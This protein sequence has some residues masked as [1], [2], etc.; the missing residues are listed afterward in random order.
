MIFANCFSKSA[1]RNHKYLGM[2]GGD[3]SDVDEQLLM[4]STPL[5]EFFLVSCGFMSL[6][7]LSPLEDERLFGSEFSMSC[8]NCDMEP[9]GA[10]LLPTLC[11]SAV[12]ELVLKRPSARRRSPCDRHA[13]TAAEMQNKHH[14]ILLCERLHNDNLSIVKNDV[15]SDN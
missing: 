11:S 3:K 10:K 13:S 14:P 9:A 1:S 4:V 2:G 7:V 5:A 12:V 15:C 8:T 6:L